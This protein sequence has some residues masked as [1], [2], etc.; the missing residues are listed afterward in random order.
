MSNIYTKQSAYQCLYLVC[1]AD[2]KYEKANEYNLKF[3]QYT[4]SVEQLNRTNAIVEVQAKYDHQ[5]LENEK[6]ALE[7]DK[8]RLFRSSLVA[9]SVL[10]LVIALLIYIYQR[11]ILKKERTIQKD[12]ALLLQYTRQLNENEQLIKRNQE[13]IVE[14]SGE[15]SAYT[16]LEESM[17]EQTAE[18]EHLHAQ[19]RDLLT[20]NNR[21]QRNIAQYSVLL[22]QKDGELEDFARLSTENVRLQKR[23]TFLCE[24]LIDG[25]AQL[26]ALRL[27]PKYLKTPQER[28]AIVQ[29]VNILYED[30]TVRLSKQYPALTEEDLLFCCLVKLH[31]NNGTIATL[32]AISP[33]SVTKRKQRI[34]ERMGWNTDMYPS[35]DLWLQSF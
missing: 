2:K 24:R 9:L 20:A 6:L 23:E 30:F 26:K 22:Q 3:W 27:S 21:L 31:L 8:S 5:K 17:K 29:A 18:M 33:A 15:I 16:D 4:D 19:N 14:L 25:N 34:K 11:R 28:E 32:F 12:K 10:L 13:R 1:F 35:F 7:L